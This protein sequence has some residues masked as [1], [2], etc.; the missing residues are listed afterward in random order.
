[1]F[2]LNINELLCA[3]NNIICHNINKYIIIYIYYLMRYFETSRLKI[4]IKKNKLKEVIIIVRNG[5]MNIV[6]EMFYKSNFYGCWNYSHN[7]RVIILW[8]RRL[9]YEL[10]VQS[11]FYN[12]LCSGPLRFGA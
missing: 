11:S 12:L 6:T 1:M 8:R 2:R 7:N 5:L 4:I 9:K 10:P 3:Y